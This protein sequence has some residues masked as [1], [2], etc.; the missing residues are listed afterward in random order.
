MV[1]LREVVEVEAEVAWKV[2]LVLVLVLGEVREMEE[3]MRVS[4]K[5]M[6]LRLSDWNVV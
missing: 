1:A 2:V 5:Q 6:R 4:K 3:A